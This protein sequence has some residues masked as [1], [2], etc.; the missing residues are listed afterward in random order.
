VVQGW[1]GGSPA[2]ARRWLDDDPWLFGGDLSVVQVC[3]GGGPMMVQR[4]ENEKLKLEKWYTEFKN[5]NH[6]LK[7]NKLFW[8]N[9]KYFQW[10]ITFGR[11]KHW[12]RKYFMPKQM[13]HKIKSHELEMEKN[14]CLITSE[15]MLH[16]ITP[17]H[18]NLIKKN[19]NLHT[20]G[21][22]SIHAPLSRL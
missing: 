13:W 12:N 17:S 2:V 5:I 6:F 11:T 15:A 22:L 3:L 19:D 16:F 1:L 4:F 7:L 8:S 20:I 9:R 21:A 10:N 18:T 14:V